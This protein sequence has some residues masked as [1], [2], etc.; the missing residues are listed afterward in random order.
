MT[1]GAG[2]WAGQGA[3]RDEDGDGG[4]EQ[5]DADLGQVQRLHGPLVRRRCRVV[6]GVEVEDLP[7]Q[8]GQYVDGESGRR[9]HHGWTRDP[10]GAG[11][12]GGRNGLDRTHGCS[13]S[14][15]GWWFEAT[16]RTW[17]GGRVMS[18]G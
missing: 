5:A 18:P 11:P 7:D 8:H 4:C 6:V 1:V 2:W 3:A 15:S 17:R 12:A 16:T 10:S 13:C 9:P 14:L